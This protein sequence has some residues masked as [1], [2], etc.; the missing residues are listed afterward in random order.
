MEPKEQN[1]QVSGQIV[2]LL[3]ERIFPGAVTVKNGSIAAV[4]EEPSA[5]SQFI[6][7]GLVDAHRHVES[8]LLSPSQ[9]GGIAMAHGDLATVSDPHEIANVLGEAGIKFMVRDAERTAL[10]IN[11][12]V[13]SCVPATNPEL[14]TSG[15]ALNAEVVGR[16]IQLP[17]FKYLAEMMN[18]PGVLRGEPEVLAKIEA[19]KKAGKPIDGHAPGLR[20]AEAE[21]YIGRGMSTDHECFSE[22]EALDKLAAG[23][24]ILI[25]EG[26]AARNFDAL[27]PLLERHAEKVMFCT[28]D[29]HPDLI[30][31]GG[32]KRH[33]TRALAL[34]LDPLSVLRA[35]SRNPVEHYGLDLGLLQPGHSADFLVVRNLKD[36]YVE[37]AYRRGA[38]VARDQMALEAPLPPETPN[39]FNA[40]FIS[41]DDLKIRS[42]GPLVR[43][44]KVVDGQLV[45]GETLL[46]AS[47]LNGNYETDV[48]RDLL[49]VAVVN[50]YK[51]A[52]VS[53]G[54]VHGFGL[55]HGALA[56]TVAHD[57]HNI[58][59][60]GATDRELASAINS[61]IKTRGGLSFVR[62][63]EASILPLPIAGL[64]SDKDPRTVAKEYSALD[65]KAHVEG[66]TNLRAP[67]MTLSFLALLVIPELK[68]SDKG[69]FNGGK[70][71]FVSPGAAA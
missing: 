27:I 39:Q 69:L 59:A 17:Q 51:E 2:D 40:K 48:A 8:T 68:L 36:F 52:P 5:P 3:N 4:R 65:S 49:K 12:G 45:T 62:G 28:D 61:V 6:T 15:A 70:W 60:V 11:Y 21:Q 47:V 43:A 56:S 58:I 23:M 35:A 18:W 32:I 38:L 44:I 19:A 37:A 41:L 29:L 42:A 1:F 50:R 9:M 71:S 66:G 16:L 63:E 24:K 10:S 53:V 64:M 54:F 30:V 57:C 34:G 25:R 33:V 7:P 55:K 67:F 14:E 26:S 13:P 31:E 22:A 20:G 46:P